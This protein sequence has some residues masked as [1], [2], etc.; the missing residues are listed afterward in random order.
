MTSLRKGKHVGKLEDSKEVL[1]TWILNREFSAKQLSFLVRDIM[2]KCRIHGLNIKREDLHHLKVSGSALSYNKLL[3]IEL[4][5][6]ELDEKVYHTLHTDLTMP[7]QWKDKVVHIL[8]F[9]TSAIAHPY[10]KMLDNGAVPRGS[11]AFT[12]LQLATLYNFPTNLSGKGQTVGIIELAG[13]FTLSDLTQYLS[14]MGIQG[15]PNVTAVSVDNVNNDPADTSGANIEVILD[16]EIIMALVPQAA[17]RIYFGPNTDAGFYD[18]IKKA[19]DDGCNVISISWGAAEVY[20]SRATL[21]SYNALFQTAASKNI[22]IL[23]A[24]GDSGSSDSAT[25]NNVDFPSSSPYVLAC[26]GT[27]VSS[28]LAV[29]TIIQETVWDN[30]STTSATGGGI[31]KVFAKPA[32]QNS[33]G[34]NLGNKRGTPDISADGDPN[35]GYVIFAEGST[36]IVGGTSCVAPLISALISKINQSLGKSVG[37][38]HSTLYAN[39]GVCRDIVQGNNGAYNASV[40]W[41]PCSGLGSIKGTDLLNLLSGNSGSP[42]PVVLSPVAAFTSSVISGV[43]PLVVNFTDQST[44]SPTSWFWD[45]SD[46]QDQTSNVQNPQHIFANAGSFTITLTVGNTAGSNSL[47]KKNYITVTVPPPLVLAPIAAFTSS[48]VSGVAPLTVNFTDQSTNKPTTWLWGFS[49]NNITSDLQNPK[50]TF[51]N[52]GSYSISLTSSNTAGTNTLIKPNYITVTAV[53]NPPV[54]QLKADFTASPLIVKRGRYVYFK[55]L[56]TPGTTSE[57]LF[58]DGSKSHIKNPYYS[59]NVPG[60]YTISLKITKGNAS[61]TVTKVNYITVIH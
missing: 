2:M 32:Y 7:E 31:S 17:I 29:T 3:N 33:V 27:N 9:D 21:N 38:I 20:W 36:T 50:H 39:P 43:A 59:Y 58:G 15:T 40:G 56:S 52:A 47:I 22:T 16:I 26:G 51:A 54:S 42:P 55:N 60:I 12:P 30:N 24:A 35:S 19:M 37:F 25:G 57:W 45:F 14:M 34:F 46:G 28:D 53:P 41:D 23:A 1:T 10:F 44:N 61:T 18:A 6:Y 5:K 49:D 13:G 4:Q 8:G 11:T 48:T